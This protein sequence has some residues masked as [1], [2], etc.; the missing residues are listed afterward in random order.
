MGLLDIDWTCSWQFIYHPLKDAGSGV[1][2]REN[3]E[4]QSGPRLVLILLPR[5]RSTVATPD[6]F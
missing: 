5:Q 6:K 1:A 2:A 3:P 4:A